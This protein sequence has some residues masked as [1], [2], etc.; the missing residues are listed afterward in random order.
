MKAKL[1]LFGMAFLL[2][3]CGTSQQKAGEQ[4]AKTDTTVKP[5]TEAAAPAAVNADSLVKII[6]AERAKIEGNL[7]SLQKKTLPTKDLR[8]QIRQKWS[9]LDFYSGNGRVVRIKS[10]PYEQIS[11]RTEEF[12][13]RDGKLI[14]AFIEDTGSQFTG[15]SEK[16]DGK[17]Y[18]FF[19]DAVIKED[20][21]TGEKE[22]S[23]RTSDGERLLQ[24]GQEYL[25]LV[26]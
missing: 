9:K 24:E 26:P 4:A 15:K 14:L 12:Y 5:A 1:T 20:N 23:I 13:F 8:A 2:F 25:T 6:D 7:K 21:Q 19:N 18:Y 22:T 16:R 3:S 11:H 17:T 10:Y